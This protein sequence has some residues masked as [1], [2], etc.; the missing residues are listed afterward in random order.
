[1][2]DIF[3]VR[4]ECFDGTSRV[5]MEDCVNKILDE[6]RRE[7]S[8]HNKKTNQDAMKMVIEECLDDTSPVDMEECA[9]EG[10]DDKNKKRWGKRVIITI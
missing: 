2:M 6:T 10:N 4:D 8:E 3:K 1:M 5:V 7:I 9:H